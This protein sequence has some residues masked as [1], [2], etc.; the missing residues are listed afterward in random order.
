M[1]S[2]A[3]SA[4]TSTAQ[5]GRTFTSGSV[6]TTAGARVWSTTKAPT[7]ADPG[8]SVR[9]ARKSRSADSCAWMHTSDAEES[10]MTKAQYETFQAL[11]PFFEVVM[12]GLRGLV[13]G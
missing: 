5:M 10:L 7:S 9:E 11:D 1:Y 12:K 4:T 8:A 6:P 2:I 3:A 13:D